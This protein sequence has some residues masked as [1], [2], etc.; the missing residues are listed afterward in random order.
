SRLESFFQT[1]LDLDMYPDFISVDGGEGGSGATYKSMAD[2]MGLPLYP[3]LIALD[4]TARRYGV[5]ER[6]R[7]IASGKLIT[8]DKVAIALAIGADA[9]NSARGF[10]MANGCIMALQCHTGKCPAGVA[11]TDPKYMDALV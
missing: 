4:D 11:T 8:P 10:M 9:V 2:S 6:I 5:R 7:I 3:A 1:M